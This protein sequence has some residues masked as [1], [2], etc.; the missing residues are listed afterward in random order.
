MSY[1]GVIDSVLVTRLLLGELGFVSYICSRLDLYVIQDLNLRHGSLLS[2]FDLVSCKVHV[3]ALDA[4]SLFFSV[5]YILI[6]Y[7]FH[8]IILVW[9]ISASCKDHMWHSPRLITYFFGFYC[10]ETYIKRGEWSGFFKLM[11]TF[12]NLSD[13]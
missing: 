13:C 2:L 8:F 1:W 10:A 6:S 5:F 12:T 9:L 3:M 7:D 4:I 11:A